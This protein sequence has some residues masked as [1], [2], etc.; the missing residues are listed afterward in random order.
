MP[1]LEEQINIQLHKTTEELLKY[2][3][4][5][6]KAEG[7]KLVFLIDV[8]INMYLVVWHGTES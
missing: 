2:G 7:E 3:K 1:V 4:G 6:P 8:S 5:T